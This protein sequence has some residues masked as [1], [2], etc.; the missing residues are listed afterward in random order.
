MLRQCACGWRS[1]EGPQDAATLPHD[2][3]SQVN[4]TVP[5]YILW[6]KCAYDEQNIQNIPW[7]RR[8]AHACA[9]ESN[10]AKSWIARLSLLESNS[11]YHKT[12]IFWESWSLNEDLGAR[13]AMRRGSS[14]R[15]S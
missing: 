12:S 8:P 6:R 14:A 11:A 7:R 13:G 5:I 3:H 10:A 9:E 2:V 1:C 15:G 4:L